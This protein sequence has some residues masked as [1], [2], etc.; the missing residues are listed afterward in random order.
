MNSS[1]LVIRVVANPAFEDQTPSVEQEERLALISLIH[2]RSSPSEVRILRILEAIFSL[3]P[4]GP[5]PG[6]SAPPVSVIFFSNI[7]AGEIH[8]MVCLSLL[9]MS[10]QFF[11][12]A[13]HGA[14]SFSS[15]T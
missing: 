14:S 15:L 4:F 6:R 2:C 11:G 5:Y 7:H 1:V 12:I 8:Y 9:S 13:I 10:K 3:F